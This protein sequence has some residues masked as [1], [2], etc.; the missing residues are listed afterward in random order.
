DDME[1]GWDSPTR[2]RQFVDAYNANPHATYY[3]LDFGNASLSGAWSTADVAYVAYTASG[4]E[5]PLPEIYTPAVL[6]TWVAVRQAYYMYF[7][8]VMTE[9]QDADPLPVQYCATGTHAG[10]YAPKL[11]WQA[12]WYDNGYYQWNQSSLDYATN[13]K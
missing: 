9:C 5:L 10:E 8:G 12:L 4:H 7:A 13:I 1:T 2:T 6:N 11:A 3:L